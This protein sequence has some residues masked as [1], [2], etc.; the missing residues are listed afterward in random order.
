MWHPGTGTNI[1][2]KNNGDLEIDALSGDGDVNINAVNANI[3]ASEDVNVACKNAT[4]TCTASLALVAPITTV[5]STTSITFTS[6]LTTFAGNA[7]FNGTMTNN[8]KNV[9]DTHGHV[10]LNDSG[11]SVEAPIV[12]VT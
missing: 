8:G 2:F 11:G 4:V 7:V 3:T 10:Q 9:G 12:G 5:N 6:P 1:H